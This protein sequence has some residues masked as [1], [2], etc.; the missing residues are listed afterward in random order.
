[1]ARYQWAGILVQR[2]DRLAAYAKVAPDPQD[3]RREGEE[4]VNLAMTMLEVASKSLAVEL[5]TRNP[6]KSPAQGELPWNQ[7]ADLSTVINY[8]LGQAWLS[9]G[10]LEQDAGKRKVALDRARELLTPYGNERPVQPIQWEAEILLADIDELAGNDGDLLKRLRRLAAL[11]MPEDP[12][13]RIRLMLAKTDLAQ[14]R[15]DETIKILESASKQNPNPEADL[16]LIEAL[17]RRSKEVQKTAPRATDEYRTKALTL[18]KQLTDRGAYWRRRVDEVIAQKLELSDVKNDSTLL[19]RWVETKRAAG[20]KEPA[21]NGLRR[22]LDLIN[23]QRGNKDDLASGRLMLAAWLFEDGNFPA[24]ESEFDRFV[25]DFPN[26]PTAA[27]ASLSAILA[28]ERQLSNPPKPEEAKAFRVKLDQHRE[29]FPNDPTL[30]EIASLTARM[31]NAEGNDEAAMEAYRSIEPSSSRFPAALQ[32]MAIRQFHWVTAP[33]PDENKEEIGKSIV[34]LRKMI[35][36][37]KT[38]GRLR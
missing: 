12:G 7:T 2:S 22:W 1:M 15:A 8:R 20:E 36:L 25:K 23:A 10:R 6:E 16:V 32:G 31:A 18:V 13:R 21:V 37:A 35:E 9:Q 19:R 11:K 26:H 29:K 27:K 3:V 4:A 5:D 34:E 28:H 24:A 17:F 33:K 38:I 14:G 30:S